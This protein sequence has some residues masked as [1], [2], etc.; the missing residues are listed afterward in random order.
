MKCQL[1][2]CDVGLS[3]EIPERTV[4]HNEEMSERTVVN[5]ER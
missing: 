2:D 3:P 1:I 5:L 4:G